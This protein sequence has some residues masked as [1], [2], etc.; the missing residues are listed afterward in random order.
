MSPQDFQRR[1]DF[2]LGEIAT[3]VGVSSPTL[4]AYLPRSVAR[5][6]DVKGGGGP[7]KR[8][9]FTF[10]SLMEFGI[11]VALLKSGV[12]SVETA[13]SAAAVFAHTGSMDRLP[14]L[15]HKSSRI[16]L[17]AVWRDGAECF[18]MGEGYLAPLPIFAPDGPEGLILLECGR[19]FARICR[20]FEQEPD[21]VVR[22]AYEEGAAD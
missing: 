11:A 12:G 17:L 20:A 4:K 9:S 13:F 8:R 3:A 19:V 2:K 10:H 7:G 22:A 21:E 18:P 5:R 6:D 14:G 15:P 1:S 16:T